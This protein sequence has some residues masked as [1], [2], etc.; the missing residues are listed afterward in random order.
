MNEMAEV[1]PEQ[2]H[3]IKALP[4]CLLDEEIQESC[5]LPHVQE[6]LRDRAGD[7]TKTRSLAANENTSLL[8]GCGHL[9]R[10]LGLQRDNLRRSN[11]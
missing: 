3:I 11:G 4:R 1:P 6:R 10:A 7:V 2:D 8:N 5:P 9:Q